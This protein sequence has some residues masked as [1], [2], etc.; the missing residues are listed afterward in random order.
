MAVLAMLPDVG[1]V[2]ERGAL[3]PD[4]DERALHAGQHARDATQV[5]VPDEPPRAR[6][7][8][9]ELLHDALLEH[10]DAGFLGGYVDKDFMSHR[11]GEGRSMESWARALAAAAR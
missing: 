7:L 11:G 10:R 1:D 3:E 5:D 6:A 4:F 9:M 8:D 2:Q